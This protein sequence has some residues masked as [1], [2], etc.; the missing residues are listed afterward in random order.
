MLNRDGVE[1]AIAFSQFPQYS[2]S[3]SGSSFNA[4]SKYYI[5][6]RNGNQQMKWSF[7]DRWPV[8]DGLVNAFVDLIKKQIEQFPEQQNDIVI[9]FSAHALPMSVR[10]TYF[11]HFH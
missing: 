9:L 10:L 4:I 8:Q 3:T 6:K 2:C 11:T 1:H 5:S 7:I